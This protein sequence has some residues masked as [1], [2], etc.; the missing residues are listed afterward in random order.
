M[1]RPK[2]HAPTMKDVAKMAGVTQPT[3]SYVINETCPVTPEVRA[4]VLAAVAELGYTPNILAKSLKSNQ[5]NTIGLL[6]PDISNPYYAAI[7][8][9]VEALLRERN[10]IVFLACTN[11]N[12]EIELR[13]IQEFL[14]YNVAGMITAYSLS[15]ATVFDLILEYN[16]PFVAMDD[17]PTIPDIPNI[18][19][20][21]EYGAFLATQHLVD[22]GCRKILLLTEPTTKL[23]IQKRI[24]GYR[25]A[26]KANA[27][28]FERTIFTSSS[29][30][31]F[32]SGYR[33]GAEVLRA[34]IDGVF[35]TSDQLAL[36]ALRY[37]LE[38]HVRIPRDV[39]LVGYDDVIMAKMS[40]PS[41]TTIAQPIQEMVAL[42]TQ[43]LCHLIDGAETPLHHSLPPTLKIRETTTE[44]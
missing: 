35:A 17:T 21:N 6:V 43:I 9:N 29:V 40:S 20:S 1:I 36:G 8:K 19:I 18:E 31:T 34:E 7:A 27:L 42:G 23:P 10:Y 44:R 24:D 30:D 38:N 16:V 13:Y 3:V 25:N 2:K 12:P 14:S 5:T 15:S 22:I 11:G 32:E 33:L 39:A 41:L 28:G 37:F 26:I 4:R